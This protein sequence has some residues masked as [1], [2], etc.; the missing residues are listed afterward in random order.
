MQG[1]GENYSESDQTVLEL[2]NVTRSIFP[3]AISSRIR[4]ICAPFGLMVR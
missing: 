4:A 1:V 2:L 3:D